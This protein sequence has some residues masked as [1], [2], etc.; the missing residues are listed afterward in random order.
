MRG[1]WLSG[2]RKLNRHYQSGGG[3]SYIVIGDMTHNLVG[4]EYSRPTENYYVAA[5]G[6]FYNHDDDNIVT[7]HIYQI[8]LPSNKEIKH[9]R[10]LAG[11]WIKPGSGHGQGYWY[12]QNH[13]F[14]SVVEEDVWHYGIVRGDPKMAYAPNTIHWN[15]KTD[16]NS[17]INQN[18]IDRRDL[19]IQAFYN[20]YFPYSHYDVQYA[21]VERKVLI[22]YYEVLAFANYHLPG[23][24]DGI[25]ITPTGTHN[26]TY[27]S[28]MKIKGVQPGFKRVAGV[29]YYG[30]GYIRYNQ[31]GLSGDKYNLLFHTYVTGGYC[32]E[33][34]I[35]A[36]T[37]CG[38]EICIFLNDLYN[39]GL[40]AGT[41]TIG[42]YYYALRL[43]HFEVEEYDMST[44]LLP[45]SVNPD[46]P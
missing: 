13:S 30:P 28:K 5:N 26:D 27:E 10:Y 19:E 41:G 2:T 46:A 29:R 42:T 11:K 3:E 43:D 18:G 38:E 33:G 21:G 35:G 22:P 7:A 6:E 8:E 4:L 15:A 9:E 14:D 16:T 40:V 36:H 34:A 23:L 25:I 20:I 39:N 44:L 45:Y 32:E 17:N 37:F 31:Q 12:I 24:S 1:H